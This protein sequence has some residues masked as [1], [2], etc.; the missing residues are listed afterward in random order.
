MYRINKNI[1]LILISLMF[2]GALSLTYGFF[3]GRM[4]LTESEISKVISDHIT[5]NKVKINR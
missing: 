2:L 1:N 3:Q 4:H 5:E